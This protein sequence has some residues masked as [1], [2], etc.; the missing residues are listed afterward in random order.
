MAGCLRFPC[1]RLQPA[2]LPATHSLRSNQLSCSTGSMIPIFSDLS[3]LRPAAVAVCRGFE[4]VAGGAEYGDKGNARGEGRLDLVG[5][6]GTPTFPGAGE[7][8]QELPA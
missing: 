5:E 2:P 7:T 6:H 3:L 1:I 4:D 8:F